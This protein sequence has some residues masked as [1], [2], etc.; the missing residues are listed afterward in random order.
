MSP[1][2]A[3]ERNRL[4]GQ[5]SV[6]GPQSPGYERIERP[7]SVPIKA[8]TRGVPFEAE[9]R[10]Q[11]ENVAR[12]PFVHRWVVAMPDV[13]W[14]IGA[15]VGSVIS[16]VG[17]IVPAAV[18][19]DI[20]CGMMAGRTTLTAEHLPDSLRQMRSALEAAVPHGRTSGRAGRDRGA[21][22]EP[23]PPALEAWAKLEPG[24][25]RI[26]ERHP[27]VARANHL[28]HLGT[29]GSGNHF[30]EICL[31]E[32]ERV[33]ALLH[34]GSRG[35]GNRIGSYF[36]ELA[37][38]AMGR[39][40]HTLPDRDLADL[41]E[42]SDDLADYLEAVEWAQSFAA[43][44]RE[45][46]MTAILAALRRVPGIPPFRAERRGAEL[47]SQLC[48]PGTSL[49]QGR[50]GHPQGRPAGS[51]GRPWNHPRQHGCTVVHRA[52]QGQPRELREL[53]SR[54]R[55]RHVA[56]RGAETVQPH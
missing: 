7:G 43:V 55:T 47:S 35:V 3:R 39:Q 17:A 45:L 51:T 8:W 25:A 29:L 34:S 41:E 23:P 54:R 2:R 28:A 50:A 38:R 46:M 52:G 37:R 5:G 30:I 44:N 40:L 26:C 48:G 42:G 22:G 32:D 13:H 49:R 53:Q 11:L 19:V 10:R 18:G 36:I 31:D 14:G 27:Q 1:P 15:T 4:P 9:A 21:W 24:F 33:W 56:P 16:T 12:L 6:P 20:G